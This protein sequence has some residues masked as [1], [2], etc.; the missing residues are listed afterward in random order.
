MFGRKKAERN[1]AAKGCG[2][3]NAEAS[4]EATSAAKNCSGKKTGTTRSCK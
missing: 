1:N 3:C 2:K 4:K